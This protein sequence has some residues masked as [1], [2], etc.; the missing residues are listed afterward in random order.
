MITST[1]KESKEVAVKEFP[2]L[3]KSLNS[4]LIVLFRKNQSGTVIVSN[5]LYEVGHVSSIWSIG[6]FEDFND[7][8]TLKNN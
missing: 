5:S 7:K 2:K 3:M 6:A 8:L 1:I 4:G